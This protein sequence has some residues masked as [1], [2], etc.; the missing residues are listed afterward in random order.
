G[1]PQRFTC[2][3]SLGAEGV[4]GGSADAVSA[5]SALLDAGVEVIAVCGR[6]EELELRLR[7]VAAVAAGAGARLHVHGFAKNMETLL[8][9]A[10]V[11][12]GKAGPASTME[13]LAVGRPVLA[14]AYA[15]LN[16]L[17]VIRFLEA[18]DL[19]GFS[20]GFAGLPATV[21]DWRAAEPRR[22]AAAETS[23]SL[24]FG[25]AREGIGRFLSAYADRDAEPE[26][27]LAPGA[28][29]LVSRE[30]L[31]SNARPLR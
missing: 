27:L 22:L 28:L 3:V 15:G 17:A 18:Y 14:A 11:V 25:A 1:L 8:A 4:T 12:A 23:A 6:N 26:R 24:G 7:K 16:E 29:A 13:A 21:L 2:L 31:D 9:A 19:G 30:R 20:G 5:I 10:D